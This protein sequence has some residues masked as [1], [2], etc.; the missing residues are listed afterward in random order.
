MAAFDPA[1]P[2]GPTASLDSGILPDSPVIADAQT[3]ERPKGVSARKWVRG[4]SPTAP[5]ASP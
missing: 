1:V 3:F 5:I 4:S 2:D